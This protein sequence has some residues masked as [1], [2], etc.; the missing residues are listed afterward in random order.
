MGPGIIS[1]SKV[2]RERESCTEGDEVSRSRDG[3]GVEGQ[4]E[5]NRVT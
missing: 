2:Q 1:V 3:G 5:N 4:S